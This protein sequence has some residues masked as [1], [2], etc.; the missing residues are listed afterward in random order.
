MYWLDF[1]MICGKLLIMP[2]LVLEDDGARKILKESTKAKTD[3]ERNFYIKK[4][5]NYI[6]E[7]S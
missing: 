2:E 3:K 7:N 6:N 5:E 1:E 4:L